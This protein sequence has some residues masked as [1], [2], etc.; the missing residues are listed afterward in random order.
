MSTINQLTAV[1]K[2]I[3]S[4]QVLIYSSDNGDTRKASINII[5]AFI[6][7]LISAVDNKN[8]QYSQPSATG[9]TITIADAGNSIWL[10]VTP[11]TGY[12]AGTIV[13]PAVA[14]CVDK[15]EILVNS[16]QAVTT[17]TINANGSTVLGAPT[18]L[19]ANAFFRLRFDAVMK[20]WYRVG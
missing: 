3:S 7:T 16:T 13:L 20:T 10:I 15:Q 8:T 2:V 11:L 6:K 14:N 5:A 4:D 18:T 19:A 17:L 9:F 1:D 12:A